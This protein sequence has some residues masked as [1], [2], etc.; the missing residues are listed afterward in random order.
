[1]V[2]GDNLVLGHRTDNLNEPPEFTRLTE[3][4]A[5][6]PESGT[7][8]VI[9]GH[10]NTFTDTEGGPYLQEGESAIFKAIDGK[11]VMVARLRVEDWQASGA[12]ANQLPPPQR[13]G[14]PA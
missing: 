7:N 9:V 13:H 5:T 14:A 2:R 11:R 3:I 8:R 4:L 1:N 12:P 6:P 10:N